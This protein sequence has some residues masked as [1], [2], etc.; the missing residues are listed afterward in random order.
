MTSNLGASYLLEGIDEQ[1]ILSEDA[2]EAA[3]S[4]V[5]ANFRPE[6]INRLDE[7]IMF[8]PL[9]ESQIGGIV[10]LLMKEINER[11]QDKQLQ[12][13]LTDEAKKFIIEH[14]FEPAFGA[15]PLRRYIQKTV[16]TLA[17]K[18]ILQNKV[19]QGDVILIKMH[20]GELIAEK[21]D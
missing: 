6:F 5:K 2:I 14:G 19:V 12:I 1:G 16:E 18:L 13:Q 3:M 4:Q 17:A 11:I 15:R 7:I 10:D 20:G 8:K 21:A 9:V